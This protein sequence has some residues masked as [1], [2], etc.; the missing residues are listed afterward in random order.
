MYNHYMKEKKSITYFS[1]GFTLIELLVVVAIIG[2]LATV[3]LASLGSARERARSAKAQSEINQMRTIMVAAQINTNRTL[4][5]ITGRFGSG[6]PCSTDIDSSACITQWEVAIDS[7][8]NA[9][10]PSQSSGSALYRDPWGAP[11]VLDENEGEGGVNDCRV[12]TLLSAGPNRTVDG[13][14]DDI[15]LIIPANRCTN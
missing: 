8:V 11:Y 2:I 1:K 12:N 13:G 5:Q 7:L 10:D 14:G 15:I 6:D 3:V 9:E 4:G